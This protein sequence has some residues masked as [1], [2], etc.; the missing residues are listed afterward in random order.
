MKKRREQR[1]VEQLVSALNPVERPR[2][3]RLHQEAPS[4]RLP[5]LMAVRVLVSA[6]DA[7]SARATAERRG[8]GVMAYVGPNGGGKTLA[9]VQDML[10]ALLAGKP[11]WSNTPLIDPRTGGPFA[12]FRPIEH[13]DQLLEIDG[14]AEVLLDEVATVANSR[15]SQRLDPRF[16]IAFQQLRKRGA[17]VR[18]TAPDI[19]RADVIFREVTQT[20]TECRGFAPDRRLSVDAWGLP[21]VW[22]PRRVFRRETFDFQEFDQWS[23]GKR[24]KADVLVREWA[25]PAKMKLD[26]R[27]A[28]NTMQAVDKIAGIVVDGNCAHCGKRARTEYCKGHSDAELAEAEVID[29]MPPRRGR[30]AVGVPVVQDRIGSLAELLEERDVLDLSDLR[31]APPARESGGSLR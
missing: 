5:V 28:Y 20:V 15:E 21:E 23:A 3:D 2:S 14:G 13:A 4:G 9:A 27:S 19:K 1:A 31:D 22:A 17:V 25:Y 18:Y 16:Q 26:P 10:P 29:L 6:S 7:K 30:R 24:E 8:A 12:S 11:C